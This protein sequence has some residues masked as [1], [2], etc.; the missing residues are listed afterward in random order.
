MFKIESLP[1]LRCA[2]DGL[3]NARSVVWM[4]S[5]EHELHCRLIGAVA[6][7]D[8]KRFLRPVEFSA[9][10]IPTEAARVAQPLRFRQIG[11]AALQLGS[12]FRH[13]CLEFVAG[14]A[15]LLLALA[16]HLLGACRPKCRCGMIRGHRKQQLV[17]LGWK[18]G[19]ITRRRNQTALGSDAD[20]D[21][22]AAA[23]LRVP[24]NVANDFAARQAAVDGEM[25]LQPFRKCW[26]CASP[27][28]FYRGAPVGIAQTHKSEVEVQ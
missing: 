23:A 5:L 25:I 13:L 26:P 14:S 4:S 21:D 7:K 1:F 28:D 11:L 8:A 15:K 20:G 6:F 16:Y 9:G 24:A 3:L 17:N 18:V 22:D 10:N 12:P 27:R 2:V 19:A